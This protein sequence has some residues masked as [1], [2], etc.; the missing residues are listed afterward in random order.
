MTKDG[1]MELKNT[2][3]LSNIPFVTPPPPF[4]V[5]SQYKYTGT[6]FLYSCKMCSSI[7]RIIVP[8]YAK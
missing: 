1:Y 5:P 3:L 7:L 4:H 6:M 2:N 8:F